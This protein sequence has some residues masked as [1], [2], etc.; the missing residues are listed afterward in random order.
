MFPQ[1]IDLNLAPRLVSHILFTLP[2]PTIARLFF[3]LESFYRPLAAAPT[4]LF[5]AYLRPGLAHI[6][7]RE[8]GSSDRGAAEA[9]CRTS[10]TFYMR[11]VCNLLSA[12]L[13]FVP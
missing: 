3:F 8:G 5:V 4:P 1:Y 10:K 11:A 2:A 13:D 7:V 12:S 9:P 6:R